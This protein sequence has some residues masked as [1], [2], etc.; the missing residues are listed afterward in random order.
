MTCMTTAGMTML[1][2]IWPSSTE[3]CFASEAVNGYWLL[4]HLDSLLA[5]L[6]EDSACRHLL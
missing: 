3:R 1:L 6:F 5:E 4:P 2:S